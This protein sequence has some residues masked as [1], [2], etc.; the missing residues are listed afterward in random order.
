MVWQSQEPP[1]N[2]LRRIILLNSRKAT[3]AETVDDVA[4][5][6]EVEAA[7]SRAAILGEILGGGEPRPAAK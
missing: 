1:R 2:N 4:V 7:T 3:N 6:R 5:V